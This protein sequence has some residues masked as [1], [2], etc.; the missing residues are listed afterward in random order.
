MQGIFFIF[1]IFVTILAVINIPFILYFL[2]FYLHAFLST[3]KEIKEFDEITKAINEQNTIA[4]FLLVPFKV[5]V[6]IGDLI[7][8]VRRAFLT[9]LILGVSLG[10]GFWYLWQVQVLISFFNWNWF[11]IL[12]ALVGTGGV[13]WICF[14]FTTHLYS[15]ED[16]KEEEGEGL[17]LKFK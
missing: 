17:S 3:E 11:D 12:L 10:F 13:C 14:K 4:Q 16:L 2:F 9:F 7:L 6:I 5:V 8:P 1:T 15:R